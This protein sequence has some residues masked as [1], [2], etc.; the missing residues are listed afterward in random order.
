MKSS[1]LYSNKDL[2]SDIFTES[3][4]IEL[5]TLCIGASNLGLKF[6]KVVIETIPIDNPNEHTSTAVI[7]LT[8]YFEGQ[9][10]NFDIPFD[11]DGNT[12][13]SVKVWKKLVEIPFGTTVSYLNLAKDL[14]N[15]K[16]IRAVANANARN[17]IP[18]IIPC[19]RVIGS[20]GNL[21]GFALGLDSKKAL[22]TLENPLRFGIEQA[23]FQF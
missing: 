6:I 19:H 9:R 18:I 4:K 11:L 23:S 1:A 21:T 12:S 2:N 15:I 17:P 8:E 5:G 16:A 10:K 20:D 13:F 14:G 3:I 22:L 7:Q